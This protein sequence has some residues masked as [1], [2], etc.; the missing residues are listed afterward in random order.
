MIRITFLHVM[1]SLFY[2]YATKRKYATIFHELYLITIPDK[3]ATRNFYCTNCKSKVHFLYFGVYSRFRS[4]LPSNIHTRCF[5]R[6]KAIGEI[7]RRMASRN[8]HSANDLIGSFNGWIFS[9]QLY[10]LISRSSK[11]SD[12]GRS[13]GISGETER[14]QS[15]IMGT[16]HW[17]ISRTNESIV[18]ASRCR[19]IRAMGCGKNETWY[20]S[21]IYRSYRRRWGECERCRSVHSSVQRTKSN[22]SENSFCELDRWFTFLSIIVHSGESAFH[23][24]M[25]GFGW[26]KHPMLRRMHSVRNDKPITLLYGSRSWIDK[27]SWDLL[28]TARESNYVNVQVRITYNWLQLCIRINEVMDVYQSD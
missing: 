9:Y 7:D 24:M 12:T 6:R 26:A 4:K 3:N 2:E 8:E 1:P 16:S 14:N 18:G 10:N 23:S 17:K 15:S 19:S 21:K 28:K 13:M 20:H 25:H 22:V 27:S 5:D 11:A